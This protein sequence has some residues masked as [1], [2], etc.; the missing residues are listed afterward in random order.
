MATMNTD[1]AV[2]KLEDHGVP[3]GRVRDPGEATRDPRLLA[4]QLSHSTGKRCA[5]GYS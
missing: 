4:R 5:L 2:Q 3:S 1:E